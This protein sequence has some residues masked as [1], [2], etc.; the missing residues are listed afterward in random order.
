MQ[1]SSL[2]SKVASGALLPSPR[3]D[4]RAYMGTFTQKRFYGVA[5]FSYETYKILHLLGLTLVILSLGGILVHVINGGSKASNT[6]RKGIM[7]T[8]GVGLL[9]LLVAGFGMLVRIGI[10]SVPAWVGG[11]LVIWLALGA[12]VGVAYKSQSLAR[13]LWIVVPVLVVL[14]A[15]LAIAKPFMGSDTATPPAQSSDTLLSAPEAQVQQLG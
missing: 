2:C 7:I 10:H 9:L 3:G 8:H 14:A 6:F 15:Y 13:K 4:F 12:F 5:M 1:L 11:K